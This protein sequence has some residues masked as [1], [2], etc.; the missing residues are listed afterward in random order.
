[1]LPCY[2]CRFVRNTVNTM[3]KRIIHNPISAQKEA[4]VE[5]F[6]VRIFDTIFSEV[7]QHYLGI[8]ILTRNLL[9]EVKHHRNIEKEWD[10]ILAQALYYQNALHTLGERVRPYLAVADEDEICIFESEELR[11]IWANI[12][13][14][15]Q[16]QAQISR[17]SDAHQSPALM[18]AIHHRDISCWYF[19]D[20]AKG[21]KMLQE[22]EELDQPQQRPIQVNNVIEAFDDW[23]D[24]VRDYLRKNNIPSA[25]IF[26]EDITENNPKRYMAATPELDGVRLTITFENY[27]ATISRIP[28]GQYRKFEKQWKRIDA[29]TP[30]AEGIYRRLYQLCEMDKRRSTGSFYTPYS[31]AKYAWTMIVKQLGEHFWQDGT[32]RIWD[33]CA[34]VG[35][36]Q[37]EIVPPDA[38]QYTYLSDKGLAEVTA[39]QENDY[40]K[41]KCGGIFQFDW[42]NDN[43]SK[44]PENLKHDL[45]NKNIRWLFFINPPYADTG[46]GL[47][48]EKKHGVKY[49]NIGDDMKNK[50]LGASANEL[51]LQFLYR[52][53][54]DFAKRGYY[55]GLFS[56][57]KWITKSSVESFRKIWHP[58][59]N[60]G[61]MLNACEHFI[62]QRTKNKLE[63]KAHGHF[64]ILFSLL[65][66][67]TKT[68]SAW[69]EQDWTYCT[70]DKNV[71]Q[72]GS[73]TFSIF[74]TDRVGFREY[75]FPV[76]Y[77]SRTK[78]F[79]V[80]G[81]AVIPSSGQSRKT[82]K[83]P[84]NCIGSILGKIH[85][86]QNQQICFLTSG[87]PISHEIMI[88]PDN[89][90]GLLIGFALFKSV[91]Y[92]WQ[93]HEDIFYAP[94]RNLTQKEIADCLL[95]ALLDGKNN[96][97]TTTVE[98]KGEKFFLQNWFNPFDETKFDWAHLSKVGQK[99]FAELTH[100]C[101]NRVQWRT[102]QTP[103][104]NNKGQGVW[105]GLYQYRTSYDAVNKTYK[106]KFGK[107]YPN[108]DLYGIPYPDSF[109]Q[110]IE[111]LRQRVEA[112]AIDLCLTAGK[113]ITRTRDTFLEQ[114]QRQQDLPSES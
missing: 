50:R 87:L 33:N 74:E 4:E 24:I 69:Q 99:A 49:S 55:L 84:V 14:F 39:I 108:Q 85:D 36:L 94:Y 13:L 44:L 71:K 3:A 86:F 46:T 82:I 72:N 1:M 2:D 37:Y 6:Y 89:Y 38:L 9:I 80:M 45:H 53:E 58:V 23:E 51:A 25:F 8:D 27:G 113:E 17:A 59:F 92:R 102:L 66:R 110:A 34:G 91:K 10:A 16:V 64:P 47:G 83:A 15:S 19:R 32:W 30:E 56:T 93:N 112:L 78:P 79:P 104:G 41:G 98:I 106:K 28:E 62:Q 97:A 63:L 95:Y 61:L 67:L 114:P 96:T 77:G 12:P 20:V 90:K 7:K 76:T 42:L 88:T 52:I 11:H 5:T 40:F 73:K 54:R 60:G 70:V 81:S 101:E 35:N 48:K 65:D 109:K 22:I 57:P 29:N 18:D 68:K 103:Y 43:E 26:Y 21:V 31:L 75:F 111:D 107:D 100:Y 105:L